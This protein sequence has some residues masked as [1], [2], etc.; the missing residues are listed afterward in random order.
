MDDDK[1][2]SE[3]DICFHLNALKK[4]AMADGVFDDSEKRF[5]DQITQKY[6]L[7]YTN[8]DFESLQNR[9]LTDEEYAQG[10]EKL[11]Q[12]PLMSKLLLKDLIS[13]GHVDGN[14]S[15]P[16]R[17]RVRE[18]GALLNISEESIQRIEQAVDSVINASL[19]MNQALFS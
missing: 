9:E 2:F 6:C 4:L 18:M 14:Y 1:F 5:I 17:K 11:K 13:L 8:L 3:T 10:L 15:E 12:N 16:E 19:L 7:S